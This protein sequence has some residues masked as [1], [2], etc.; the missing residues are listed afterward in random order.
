[1]AKITKTAPLQGVVDDGTKEIPIVN[2]FGKLICNIYLRPGDYAIVDRFKN[3]QANIAEILEPLKNI[4]L[5]NDGSAS[6]DEDWE[7][8]KEV[9]NHLKQEINYLFD[10]EE[11][12]EIFAKRS[13]F[14]SVGGNFF[15]E[16]VIEA[17]GNIIAE[18]IEEEARL[19]QKRTDK[20]LADLEGNDHAGDTAEN[21]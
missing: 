21:A 18:T 8:L 7:K 6:F 2:K 5:K 14:S 16:N 20:Y 15:V 12:D 4:S 1:M 10:M 17:I 13:P 3:L 19:S 11:A 9:E